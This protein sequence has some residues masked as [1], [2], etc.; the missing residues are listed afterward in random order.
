[1]GKQD[2]ILAGEAKLE[3][4]YKQRAVLVQMLTDFIHKKV[5]FMEWQ[6]KVRELKQKHASIPADAVDG[7]LTYS[8]FFLQRQENGLTG[9]EWFLNEEGSRLNE[10]QQTMLKTWTEM[11]PRLVQ[12]TDYTED[13]CRFTD[14]ISGEQFDVP[15]SEENISK[16]LPWY[17]TVGMLEPFNG[18]HL[19]H[20]VRFFSGPAKIDRAYQKVQELMAEH[21]QE[22]AEVLRS[23]Y[24]E[25]VEAQLRDSEK[26]GDQTH[27]IEH[28][29]LTYQI[30][31]EDGL[32]SYLKSHPEFVFDS[33]NEHEK[34]VSW[35][36][37]WHVY[38]DSEM[39][40]IGHTGVV[41]GEF[42]VGGQ[43]LTYTCIG[44]ENAEGFKE[45]MKKT[46]ASLA[47][48]GEQQNDITVPYQAEA[49]N[50][51]FVPEVDGNEAF[52]PFAQ[53]V[54][55]TTADLKIPKLGNKSLR[56][57]CEDGEQE[58]A[59]VWLKEAEYQYY[60]N[61]STEGR[62][63]DFNTLRRELGLPF[64]PFV[65]GGKDR[66]TSL[67]RSDGPPAEAD[68]HYTQEE[69]TLYQLLGFR[70]D[71]VENFYAK[72]MMTF[73]KEK[74]EGKSENTMRKYRNNLFDLRDILESK[75]LTSWSELDE[76]FWSKVF[77]TELFSFYETTSKTQLK[78]F[79][80]TMKMLVK[81]LDGRYKT[82]LAGQVNA[83][84]KET[85]FI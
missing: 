42:K 60:S 55:G 18:Q 1:M 26:P 38:R 37:D 40:G 48:I 78:D 50:T 2:T 5:R 71:T 24:F 22:G 46:G 15:R 4:F 33:W 7:L 23:H 68:P 35:T 54:Q 56:E 82:D 41:Y 11:E 28:F 67:E 80:S 64:S 19:F 25:I 16:I 66:V 74:I 36:G 62:T 53:A 10:E 13:T 81:W 17:G 32:L 73:F 21:H 52:G 8:L 49:V 14:L 57:L 43:V 63:A 3:R 58:K 31:N 51:V 72:D 45:H 47:F 30:Q 61:F 20:G 27:V 6:E 76:A 70:P 79:A 65:A 77:T 12:A 85:G 75:S 44:K 29:E 9:A 69:I 34:V 39:E 59:D 83:A 84:I